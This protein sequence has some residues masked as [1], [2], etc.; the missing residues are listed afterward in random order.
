MARLDL[1]VDPKGEYE[2]K[3]M[4][5]EQAAGL[6]ESGDLVWIPSTHVPPAIMAVLATRE[7]ELRDVTIRGGSIPNMG[8]FRAD[9]AGGGNPPVQDAIVPGNRPAPPDRRSDRPPPSR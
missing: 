7:R 6:V 3:L 4:T 2:R 1:T 9:A 5:P 8:W